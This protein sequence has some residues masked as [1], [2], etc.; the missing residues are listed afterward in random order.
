MMIVFRRQPHGEAKLAQ[1]GT[2][3]YVLHPDQPAKVMELPHAT[4]D[5]AAASLAK[6]RRDYFTGWTVVSESDEVDVAAWSLSEEELAR[7]AA[8][9]QLV[10]QGWAREGTTMVMPVRR[11]RDGL[12]A[13]I[14]QAQDITTLH[15][16]LGLEDGVDPLRRPALLAR[17]AQGALPQLTALTLESPWLPR[18]ALAA[19]PLKLPKELLENPRLERLA[20]IG[21]GLWP[22]GAVPQLAHLRLQSNFTPDEVREIAAAP[23]LR[24]LQITL[25]RRGETA[26]RSAFPRMNLDELTI[27]ALEDVGA[28][29]HALLGGSVPALVQL[30]GKP[31]PQ[32]ATALARWQREQPTKVLRTTFDSPF[33]PVATALHE[34]FQRLYA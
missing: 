30:Q 9:D 13:T 31:G 17:L 25:T 14:A 7:A 34:P 19:Q 8:R 23:E 18:M 16:L 12:N 32:M 5:A 29:I 33:V 27:E 26:A 6:I 24:T 20:A 15:V 21:V 3:I 28:M 11:E 10:R 4:A 2:T 22:S 1:V